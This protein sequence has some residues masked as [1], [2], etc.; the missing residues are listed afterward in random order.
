MEPVDG[1]QAGRL[2]HLIGLHVEMLSV[3]FYMGLDLKVSRYIFPY[4]K[5]CS[6]ACTCAGD[7]LKFLRFHTFVARESKARF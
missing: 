5:T 1:M 3:V 6:Y 7:N 4:K 2:S